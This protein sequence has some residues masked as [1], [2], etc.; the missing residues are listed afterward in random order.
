MINPKNI[1][2]TLLALIG[3]ESLSFSIP[4]A[5]YAQ[6]DNQDC[7]TTVVAVRNELK[8]GR[9]LEVVLVQSR[10]MSEYSEEYPTGRPLNYQFRIEGSAA[11]DVMYSPQFLQ[12]LSTQVINN[13]ASA[14][15]VTFGVNRTG[16][17]EQ[18]GYMGEG[19]VEAFRCVQ[20][21]RSQSNRRLAWG[22]HFCT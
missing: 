7:S 1:T 21:D 2:F 17:G 18:Y 13:C 10:D 14:G 19:R 12:A 5:A 6:T 22:Y 15:S 11:D 9:D 4:L 20:P 3:I 8:K 16:W